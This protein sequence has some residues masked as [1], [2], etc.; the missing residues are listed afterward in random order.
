MGAAFT[1]LLSS[2]VWAVAVGEKL[3]KFSCPTTEGGQ[4]ASA[5]LA[6]KVVAICFTA[7]WVKRAGEEVRFL[8]GLTR[9]FKDRGLV[10]LPV[11][12][13]EDKARAA[14]FAAQYQLT[15]KLLLDSGQLAKLFG[16]NGLPDLYLVDRAGLLRGRVVGYGPSS[17]ESIRKALLPLL[18]EAKPA[19]AKSAPVKP[20][21]RHAPPPAPAATNSDLPAALRAYAHLQLGAAHI[22]IGDAFINAGHRDGGHYAEAVKELQAGLAIDPKNVDL[23]VWTGVAYERKGDAA[24]AVRAYQA[25]LALDAGNGYAREG[26]RRLRGLPPTPPPPP[27]ANTNNE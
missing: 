26:L 15:S 12:E 14:E 2:P 21:V 16:V 22:S 18:E 8:Q 4:V 5:D 11:I 27:S 25:A 17:P 3:P 24:E 9:E 7:S 13:R 6:G 19:P 23:L 20:A 1:A 10:V